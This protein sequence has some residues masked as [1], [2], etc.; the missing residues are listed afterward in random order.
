MLKKDRE[1]VLTS[2][3]NLAK[4]VLTSIFIFSTNKK[5]NLY[6]HKPPF[7]YIKVGFKGVKIIKACFR[8]VNLKIHP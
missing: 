3:H 1:V 2:T 8:D 4:W 7:Y 6:P 5:N